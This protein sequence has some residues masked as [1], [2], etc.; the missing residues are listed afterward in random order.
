MV[1]WSW[2][3][4]D[5]PGC[6]KNQVEIVK[7]PQHVEHSVDMKFTVPKPLQLNELEK[8]IHTG[9]YEWHQLNSKS[10]IEF[11]LLWPIKVIQNRW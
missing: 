2:R 6:Q 5:A 3:F 10:V 9:T 11:K 4:A 8:N 7:F 1:N